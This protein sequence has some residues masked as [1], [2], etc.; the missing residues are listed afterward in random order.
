MPVEDHPLYDQW[1]EALDKLKEANDCYRAAKMARHP[2]GSLA[3]L[4]T[5]LNYAQA[6]FD[7]IA[8]QIDADRS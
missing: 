1:S 5:H 6:D 4:K 2:E 8:D 3:A 7:K